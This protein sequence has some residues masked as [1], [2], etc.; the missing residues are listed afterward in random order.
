MADVKD[1]VTKQREEAK[2]TVAQISVDLDAFTA[3]NVNEFLSANRVNDMNR[4]NKS[5]LPFM[6]SVPKEW[7]EA[8]AVETYETL[9]LIVWRCL[10]ERIVQLINEMTSK[11]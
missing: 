1:F 4:I 10:I 6:L 11:N 5:I 2:E 9:H 7:G 8:K 3:K